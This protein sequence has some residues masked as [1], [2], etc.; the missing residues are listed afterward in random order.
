M[1][2]AQAG[3]SF[4]LWI[5]Y[6]VWLSRRTVSARQK[7]C[8][9]CAVR[10]KVYGPLL[11]IVGAALLMIGLGTVLSN[12]GLTPTGMPAWAWLTVSLSGLAFVHAQVMATAII[13]SLVDSPVTKGTP[14]AFEPSGNL[15]K[16]D[17]P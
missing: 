15:G 8:H 6:G 9:M 7:L 10:R 1:L 12:N 16:H 4:V 11:F 14:C 13:L 2:W 17:E 3:A 5:G